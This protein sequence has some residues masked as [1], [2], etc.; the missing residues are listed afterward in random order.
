[1]RHDQ[2]VVLLLKLSVYMKLPWVNTTCCSSSLE[3]PVTAGRLQQ[4]DKLTPTCVAEVLMLLVTKTKV[5]KYFALWLLF[6]A[7]I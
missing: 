1:M 5:E 3:E 4:V 2:G 7:I 6:T